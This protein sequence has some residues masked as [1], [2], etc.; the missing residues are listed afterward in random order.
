MADIKELT[1]LRSERNKTFD[2]G[3][4]LRRLVCRCKPIHY[5]NGANEWA[6]IV[7]NFR[8]EAD[9][10]ITDQNKVSVGFRKDKK[11]F[12]YFGLRYDDDHQFEATI[13][14]VKLDNAEQV[15]GDEVS[16]LKK[17]SNT[18][19][20]HQLNPDIEIINKVNE[21]SLKNFVK[22]SNPI[23]DFKIVEEIHLKGLGCANLKKENEYIPD[24]YGRFLFIDENNK[25]K[26]W[27]NSPFFEDSEKERYKGLNHTLQ[28]IDG[29]LIY[30]KQPTEEGKI[31]LL[32]AAY[33]ILIDANT[34]YSSTSDGR[35]YNAGADDWDVV[36]GAATG[37][38][39]SNAVVSLIDAMFDDTGKGNFNIS[40]SFF[41]FDTSDLGAGAVV[42]SA[43]LS[44]YGVT[45]AASDVSAQKGTQADPITTADF[46]SFSGSEYAH[47][48]WAVDQYNDITFNAQGRSDIE[49]E[50][51][52]KICCR[53]YDCDYLD[54]EPTGS[55][56]N[57]C[58]FAE[59]TGTDKD[60]KLVI[61]YSTAAGPDNLKSVNTV[62]VASIKS[63]NSIAIA[64][65]K[66][67]NTIV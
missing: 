60:P 45:N 28:E 26:F 9:K 62:A 49:V 54:V 65:V 35:V 11:L 57:G 44:L 58:Y 31:D 17:K 36:H 32:L 27:I 63:I 2:L 21:V 8:E 13:K 25:L 39:I 24:K 19:I 5:K 64:S 48:A 66:S 14:E 16:S 3:N 6:D 53:E 47:V 10:F 38:S 4:G 40:R 20:S 50:G 43:V 34:Y 46:D 1:K 42:S 41:Y 51:T 55:K 52:T 30:T 7:L 12:K 67:V 56:A 23:E 29:H 61:E 22:V 59:E 18:E 15:K 33:P 37:T